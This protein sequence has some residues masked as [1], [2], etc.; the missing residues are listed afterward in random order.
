MGPTKVSRLDQDEVE[1]GSEYRQSGSRAHCS[2]I[3]LSAFQTP[4]CL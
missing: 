3:M 1:A 2:T 4:T